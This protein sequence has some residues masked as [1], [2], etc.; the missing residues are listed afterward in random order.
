MNRTEMDITRPMLVAPSLPP[1]TRNRVLLAAVAIGLVAVWLRF[2][3]ISATF[4][5]SDQAAMAYLVRHSFG[6][7]WI[8]AHDYGPVLPVIHLIV[9]GFCRLAGWPMGEAVARLPMALLGL[10]QVAATIALMR[11]LGRSWV[12]GLLAAAVCAVL[13]PLVAGGHYPWGYNT[14]WLLTGTLALWA[15][16]SWIDEPRRR[17]LLLAAVALALHCLS[18]L[19][20]LALPLT[21]L[22]AWGGRRQQPES[23]T[24]SAAT[25]ADRPPAKRMVGF[26]MG[27]VFPC[28]FALVVI[29]VSW[30][31]TGGG[32]VGRLLGKTE[33]GTLGWH[34]EQILQ[35]PELWVSQLGYIYGLV[36]AA[37]LLHGAILLCRRRREGL[38]A[39]WAFVGLLP[40]LLLARWDRIGYPAH[41]FYEVIYPSTLLG[42]VLLAAMWRAANRTWR[43]VA[44]VAAGLSLG[45]LAL[46]S[47]GVCL[48][49]T[50]F[51]TWT[52]I[53]T[54]WGNVRPDSGAK[55]A[56][57]YVREHVP[58]ETIILALHTNDGMELPV[59]EYYLGRKVLADYVLPPAAA[60][61]LV[62]QF[63][64]T[65][66]VF[67]VEAEQAGL[68]ETL[69]EFRRVATFD[70][71]GEMVRLI[72]ARRSLALP[73]VR[74]EITRCNALY[75]ER[76]RPR[77]VP[78]PL[79]A[80][81]HFLTVLERYQE[82]VRNCKETAP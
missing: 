66:D 61:R 43:G 82:A 60:S 74:D 80:P 51:R 78:L 24:S 76:Y 41:Y 19:Y 77:R 27:F 28:L 18:G 9:A 39:F 32:Q 73:E 36:A 48:P 46:G 11:R 6:F 44:I 63:H 68:V 49:G 59:A 72:Y 79:P 1:M 30:Y 69:P 13:P 16:L 3:N 22:L 21:L 52:G 58:E 67:I 53:A 40:L 45:Q 15:T 42:V 70:R 2:W 65:V 31:Q 57:F 71:D 54:G 56:G 81:D 55:A 5:S 7:R 75:D 23:I 4:E 12:E 50:P 20:S 47:A 8:F 35:L 37:G 25:A 26:L 62:N 14:I 33:M 10:V 38:L 29:A 34:P 64:P 17:W